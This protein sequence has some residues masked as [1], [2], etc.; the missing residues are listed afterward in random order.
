MICPICGA[1]IIGSSHLATIV[2]LVRHVPN[3]CWCGK[4]M[5]ANAFFKQNVIDFTIICHLAPKFTKQIF[6]KQEHSWSDAVDEAIQHYH[7]S[8]NGVEK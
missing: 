7:D 1:E 6:D 2:H 3:E 8:L 5:G 4:R